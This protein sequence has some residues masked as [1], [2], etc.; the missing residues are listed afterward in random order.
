[1]ENSE[2]IEKAVKVL[3]IGSTGS[4]KS[5]TGQSLC[6]RETLKLLRQ[7]DK[8]IF[9]NSGEGEACTMNVNFAQ[10]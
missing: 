6:S 10:V 9:E 2:Q 5:T 8:D 1:M 7:K 3:L 4:G